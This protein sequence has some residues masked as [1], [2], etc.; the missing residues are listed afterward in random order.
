[1]NRVQ[2][3]IVPDGKNTGENV[4]MAA[5]LKRVHPH[6]VFGCSAGDIPDST[7]IAFGSVGDAGYRSYEDVIDSACDALMDTMFVEEHLRPRVIEKLRALDLTAINSVIGSMTPV[8][9]GATIDPISYEGTVGI[10]TRYLCGVADQFTRQARLRHDVQRQLQEDPEA[11]V[12]ELPDEDALDDFPHEDVGGALFG[13]VKTG[14]EVVLFTL[15]GQGETLG[16]PLPERFAGLHWEEFS[17]ATGM[18]GALQSGQTG[19]EFETDIEAIQFAEIIAPE[20]RAAKG[21]ELSS[22]PTG[23][24]V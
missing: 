20:V 7:E 3:L 13:L 12:V 11:L 6:A 15:P 2:R 10:A 18:A 1:M 4:M 16:P 17:E 9:D 23:P 21:R 24:D 19:A 5:I 14:H 22:A 8:R